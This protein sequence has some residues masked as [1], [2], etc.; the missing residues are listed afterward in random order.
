VRKAVS[1]CERESSIIIVVVGF[2]VEICLFISC[3]FN[4]RCLTKIPFIEGHR[5]HMIPKS[6]LAQ[7]TLTKIRTCVNDYNLTFLKTNSVMK[8]FNI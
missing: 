5:P 8:R 6:I 4:T 2:I 1:G 7:L 3:E